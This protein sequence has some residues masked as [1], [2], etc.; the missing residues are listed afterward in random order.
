MC[1]KQIIEKDSPIGPYNVIYKR[2][3]PK[4]NN[5]RYAEFQCPYC[6]N[7]FSAYLQDIKKGKTRSCGCFSKQTQNNGRFQDLT[8]K[9]FGSLTVVGLSKHRS[10]NGKGIKWICK[11]D[12]GQIVEKT[13]LHLTNGHSKSCGVAGCPYK[14]QLYKYRRVD[15]LGKRFGKLLVLRCL[16]KQD[17]YGNYLWECKCDCG[18]H[19]IATTNSLT[20]GN[21]HSCGCVLSKAEEKIDKI[22][23]DLNIKFE[24]QKTFQNC[25][26]P[27]TN[28]KLRFD[29]YI[30]RFQLLIEYNGKQHYSPTSGWCTQEIVQKTQYRDMIK[31]KWCENNG[32][33]LWIIPYTE[34][35]KLSKAYFQAYFKQLES[36]DTL[37]KEIE[38]W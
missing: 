8:G 15:L 18:K 30:P 34:E 25:I 27:L 14:K 19:T 11:C 33:R 26:N 38:E 32:Y 9:R 21:T 10:P 37:A 16:E 23:A 2:D 7:T 29:F 13:A 35:Q 3:L 20:S 28:A 4:R 17:K 5:L 22:L 24:R 6:Y 12:C 31:Q 1:K 36:N